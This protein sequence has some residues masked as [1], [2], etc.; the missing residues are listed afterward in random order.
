M[1]CSKCGSEMVNKC[2]LKMKQTMF[3]ANVHTSRITVG[4]N[5]FIIMTLVS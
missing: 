5:E 3:S 2:L 1:G 4:G